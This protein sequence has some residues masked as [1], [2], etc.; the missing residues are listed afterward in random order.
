VFESRVTWATSV[1]I[2]VFLG[3]SVLELRPMY[4]TDVRQRDVRQKHRLMPPPKWRR[5]HKN[6]AFCFIKHT[7]IKMQHKS[8]KNRHHYSNRSKRLRSKTP[9]GPF[10]VFVHIGC[11]M[12]N[13][14][15]CTYEHWK[16]LFRGCTFPIVT[17]QYKFG[18]S[19]SWEGNRRS[20]VALAMPHRQ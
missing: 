9:D 12:P 5:G 1:P 19:V 20:S 16:P 8:E 10:D 14:P 17:K 7:C 3:F 15:T 13:V 2:L 6:A 18:T 4:V 11:W